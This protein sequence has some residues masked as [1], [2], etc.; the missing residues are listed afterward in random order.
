[1]GKRWEVCH[2]GRV[3]REFWTRRG[4]ERWLRRNASII[5]YL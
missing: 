4:M 1:M 3:V 2:N 5:R